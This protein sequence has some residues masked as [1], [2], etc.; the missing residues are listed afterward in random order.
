MPMEIQGRLD[1]LFQK[2]DK[3]SEEVG[4]FLGAMAL[5]M[6]QGKGIM[7]MPAFLWD[8]IVNWR[9][10]DRATLDAIKTFLTDKTQPGYAPFV[11]GLMAAYGIPFVQGLVGKVDPTVDR[12]LE[13]AQPVA[14]ATAVYTAL[15]ALA[16]FPSTHHNS[17]P[18]V[19]EMITGTEETASNAANP[20]AY[21]EFAG[22]V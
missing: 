13:V 12:A 10:P 20:S 4:L 9:I 7:D 2:V 1:K 15:S 19:T 22:I 3:K 18:T 21:V 6:S 16:Y 5:P 11:Y 14:A 8:K 17:F